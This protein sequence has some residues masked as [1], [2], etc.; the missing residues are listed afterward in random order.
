MALYG[1]SSRHSKVEFRLYVHIGSLLVI[2]S[3]LLTVRLPRT[4]VR[5]DAARSLD[6]TSAS[7]SP[8]PTLEALWRAPLR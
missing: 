7:V 4:V 8:A 1:T 3:A 5:A 6:R 2:L